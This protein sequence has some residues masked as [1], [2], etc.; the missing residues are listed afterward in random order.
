[1]VQLTD[2][3]E[4]M[5]LWLDVVRMADFEAI[6]WALPAVLAESFPVVPV[7]RRKAQNWVARMRDVALVDSWQ[8]TFHGVSIVWPTYLAVGKTAPRLNRQTQRHEI[9]VAR[10]A[11]RYLAQ[12]Y[13]WERDRSTLGGRD[14]AA[15][16]VAIRDGLRELI[17]VELTPKTRSRY[18]EIHNSHAERLQTDVSRVIYLCTPDAA[19]VAAREADRMLIRRLRNRVDVFPLMDVTGTWVGADDAPWSG[20]L[21]AAAATGSGPVP[22]LFE[23][24]LG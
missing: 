10:V 20:A 8:P 11:A 21:P 12:G 1:M 17:E 3:D 14:H 16:G 2:R 13:L 15:D 22:E 24:S 5:L 9:A 4:A 7:H 6:R 23:R 19:T 18:N